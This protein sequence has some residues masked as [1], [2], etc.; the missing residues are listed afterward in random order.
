MILIPLLIKLFKFP[1]FFRTSILIV[2]LGSTIVMALNAKNF[3]VQPRY[4]NDTQLMEACNWIS[5]NTNVDDV[6]LTQPFTTMEREISL[7]SALSIFPTHKTLGSAL[8]DEK[9]ALP[10]AKLQ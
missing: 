5:E 10:F 2:F 6:F 9:H 3:S 8:F 1:L 7:T 4:Y